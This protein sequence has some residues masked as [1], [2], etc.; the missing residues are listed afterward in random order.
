M[1]D[2]VQHSNIDESEMG[3][4]HGSIH[5][6][7]NAIARVRATMRRGASL[8]HCEL[9]AEEIPLARQLAVEGCRTCVSCQ[10]DLEN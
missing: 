3:Q 7:E 2:S 10:Q 9:C 4:L 8:S 6:H 1:I 5:L